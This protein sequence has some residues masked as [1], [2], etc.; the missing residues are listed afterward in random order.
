MLSW[1]YC[2]RRVRGDEKLA[3]LIATAHS[4]VARRRSNK[5]EGSADDH[6]CSE[7]QA[8]LD[9]NKIDCWI[10]AIGKVV[11]RRGLRRLSH[12]CLTSAVVDIIG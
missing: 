2:T 9:T 3:V 7:P 11:M 10:S 6:R 8:H 1:Y 5:D 12:R 4:R